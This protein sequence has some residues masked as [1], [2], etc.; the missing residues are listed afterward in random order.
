MEK[1]KKDVR[2]KL[3]DVP[4]TFEEQS[5]LIK[6]LKLL[7]PDSDPAWDCITAYHVWL[8]DVLWQL[9]EKHFNAA[10]NE[11]KQQRDGLFP[12]KPLKQNSHKYLSLGF[13][14]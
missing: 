13:F 7:E 10:V 1:F 11:E 14:S 4:T 3:I 8:E 2:Q 6:Y 9:Q 12:G 5:K